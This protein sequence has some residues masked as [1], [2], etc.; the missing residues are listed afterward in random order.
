[1]Q[2]RWF[3]YK[4]YGD[5]MVSIARQMAQGAA[6][7]LKCQHNTITVGC[8]IQ[9]TGYFADDSMRNS[10]RDESASLLVLPFL[11]RGVSWKNGNGSQELSRLARLSNN[12]IGQAVDD[13]VHVSCKTRLRSRHLHEYTGCGVVLPP[14][15]NRSDRKG[16]SSQERRKI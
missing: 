15:S 1:M 11:F 5:E 8:L 9:P 4:K 7:L 13:P 3:Q 10:C 2:R 6:T 12:Q 14:W 16:A